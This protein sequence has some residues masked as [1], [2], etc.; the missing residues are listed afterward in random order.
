M[1]MN[2]D[3]LNKLI[4][5]ANKQNLL[6]EPFETVLQ[7]FDEYMQECEEIYLELQSNLYY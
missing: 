3:A 5:F 1:A 7:Q 4:E 6:E 2:Y